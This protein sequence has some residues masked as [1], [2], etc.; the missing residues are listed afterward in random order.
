MRNAVP[1]CLRIPE[2]TTDFAGM[3]TPYKCKRE[4]DR[5]I[6]QAYHGKCLRREEHLDHTARK[7][8]FHDFLDD[9]QE[10]SVMHADASAEQIPHAQDLWQ[11]LIVTCGVNLSPA[12]RRKVTH[13]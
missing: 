1:S 7:Q 5:E 11:G 2:K 3:F 9:G 10:T 4:T 13:L 8:D 6:Y 12:F